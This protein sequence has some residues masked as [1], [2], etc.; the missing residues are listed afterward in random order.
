MSE[1]DNKPEV[2]Q[3]NRPSISRRDILLGLG[4]AATAAYAGAVTASSDEHKHD[5]HMG[6]KHD[7]SKHKVKSPD[8]LDAVNGCVDKGR[9]CIAHC[10]VTYQEGDTTLADCASKAHE[11]L[12]ICDGFA[13]LLAA[14]SE[15]VKPYAKLCAQVCEDCAKECRKHDQHIECNACAEAC[16]EVVDQ[17]KLRLS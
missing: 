5:E 1:C 4:A 12:A 13:Y 11:M 7:H 9:R 10:L 6:M 2:N 16:E 15:Y 14:N 17:I 8:V 3:A